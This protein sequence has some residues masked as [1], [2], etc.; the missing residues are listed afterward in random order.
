MNLQ[1]DIAKA[2]QEMHQQDTAILSIF[3][4]HYQVKD[5]PDDNPGYQAYAIQAAEVASALMNLLISVKKPN[6]N[7]NFRALQDLTFALNANDFWVK[8]S[9]VLMP[10]LVIF[11]NA[12]KDAV[13]MKLDRARMNDYASLDK[14][15]CG[16]EAVGLEIFAMI[17]YLLGGP[18]LMAT[19]SIP[20]KMDLAPYL[21]G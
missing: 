6:S 20:L 7:R 1:E 12:H 11:M 2:V 19:T 5:K 17:A 4:R 3:K 21:L 8:N 16:S 10:L 15:V 14:L 18:M 9:P 13:S